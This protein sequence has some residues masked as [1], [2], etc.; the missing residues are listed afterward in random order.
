PHTLTPHIY[1]LSLHD[2]LP[3][4]IMRD[5]IKFT[6]AGILRGFYLLMWS[7]LLF[8]PAVYK[9]IGYALTDYLIVDFPILTASEA[10][11]ESRQMMR[12]R[13]STR[14]NSSHVSISYAVF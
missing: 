3:I 12:D 1:T 4:S 14:L 9:G 6:W 11:T 2:A 10:I 7:L 8:F 13:K 5:S